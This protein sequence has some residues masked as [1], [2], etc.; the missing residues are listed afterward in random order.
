MIFFKA[1]VPNIFIIVNDD[2]D[3]IEIDF[4]LNISDIT[5]DSSCLY[6]VLSIQMD[7]FWSRFMNICR[8][9]QIGY[10]LWETVCS[11][12]ICSKGK[13]QSELV[14]DMLSTQHKAQTYFNF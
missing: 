9:V 13:V 3:W 1:I 12:L 10:H 5:D 14:F 11:Q 7:E 6:I 8:M 2:F 4:Y